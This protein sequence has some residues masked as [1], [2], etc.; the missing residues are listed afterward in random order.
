MRTLDR[1]SLKPPL[2]VALHLGVSRCSPVALYFR[3]NL[4]GMT[5]VL[6][7]QAGSSLFRC[8]APSCLIVRG[9]QTSLWKQL[10]GAK[11]HGLASWYYYPP[12]SVYV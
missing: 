8:L 11:D 2:E 9:S 1:I 6:D 3:A 10:E 4:Y 7:T 12:L 5:W